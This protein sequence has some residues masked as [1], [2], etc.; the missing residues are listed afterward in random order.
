MV[1]PS[2]QAKVLDFGISRVLQPGSETDVPSSTSSGAFFGTPSD[3]APEQARGEP[4]DSRSDIFAFGTVLY[5][6]ASGRGPFSRPSAPETMNAV[7]NE[8]HTP[9]REINPQI[10]PPLA[11]LIDRA[12]AKDPAHRYQS[13]EDVRVVLRSMAQA[14]HVVGS[15]PEESRLSP[16]RR[17]LAALPATLRRG[18]WLHTARRRGIAAAA[19]AIILVAAISGGLTRLTSGTGS[20]DSVAV[21]P[22]VHENTPADLEYLAEGIGESV[23]GRLSQLSQVRVMARTTMSTY[24]G[25]DIDPRAVGRELG[26]KAVLTGEVLQD[27]NRIVVRLELVDVK[28]GARLWGRRVRPTALRALCAARR[29]RAGGLP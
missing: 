3:M 9:V 11:N 21:L 4:A 15:S 26:V 20:F 23:T 27:D 13:I 16:S 5:E 28:D 25:R 19:A 22:F 29:P 2:D 24:R 8:P 14:A 12:L 18:R 6:M 7:I 1:T 10:P 17:R